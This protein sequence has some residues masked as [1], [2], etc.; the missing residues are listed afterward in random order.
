MTPSS[1][2]KLVVASRGSK[3]AVRQ[4][5]MVSDLVVEAHPGLEIEI[6][7]VKTTGDKDQRAFGEI[8]G[9]GL[10]TSEVEREVVESRADLAVHSAKDLTAELFDG[11]VIVCVPPRG[12]VDDVVVGGRG[13]TGEERIANLPP[14]ATVGTSSIRRRALLSELRPDLE[15]VTFRGNL[16]TR[17]KK[18]AEGRVDVAI[19]AG[20]GIDRL[21]APADV[22]PLHPERWTPPPGQGAIAIEASLDR[23][24]VA[25]LLV[26]LGDPNAMAEVACERAFARQLE[27]GCSVPL[28]CLARASDGTLVANGFLA[29]PDASAVLRDKISGNVRDTEAL[30][31]ELGQAILGAGGDEILD[32]LRD[33]EPPQPSPP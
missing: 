6:R 9:K 20:A 12:R 15:A 30:G 8:G 28:G 17:L 2:G 26:G 11:C 4:A 14:G 16:D 22:A 13:S 25:D 32:E 10:F 27:G 18:V 33:T 1:N 24:D 29:T 5:Q 21:G 7:T 3:L 19:L 31:L 23:E